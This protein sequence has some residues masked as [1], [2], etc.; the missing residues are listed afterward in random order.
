MDAAAPLAVADGS[1][2]LLA[3]SSE[4]AAA[5]SSRRGGAGSFSLSLAPA[6]LGDCDSLR[7]APAT[8]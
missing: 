1:S 7:A 8:R 4:A 6:G 3:L 5:A 2:L